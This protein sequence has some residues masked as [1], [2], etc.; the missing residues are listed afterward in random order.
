[1]LFAFSLRLDAMRL[2]RP[3]AR[4][5]ASV[6]L[7]RRC[8]LPIVLRPVLLRRGGATLMPK[9]GSRRGLC[10]RLAEQIVS[11]SECGSEVFAASCH[12]VLRKIR[13]CFEE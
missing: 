10:L 11:Q 3:L 1:M 2:F 7:P 12:A 5:A 4:S 9:D 6:G 8:H 13:G